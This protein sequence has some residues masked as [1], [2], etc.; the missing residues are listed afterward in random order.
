[1]RKKQLLFGF[2]GWMLFAAGVQAKRPAFAPAPYWRPVNTVTVDG[3]EIVYAESGHGPA[4]LLVHGWAG[5]LYNW[6]EVMEPLSRSFR[7]VA[8]DLPG[9]GQSGCDSQARY[10]TTAYAD[11]LARFLDTLGIEQTS[12]LG[13]S[14]GGQIAA[15][16]ALRH[17]ERVQKLILCDA[18]GAGGFPAVMK[19]AAVVLRPRSMIPLLH[20]AFPV[21]AD[22]LAAMPES[23]RMRVALAEERYRSEVRACTGRALSDALKSMIRHGLTDELGRIQAP[24]LVLWGS[25]DDLLPVTFAEAFAARIPGA[26]LAVIEGGRHTPMQWRPEQFVSIV[27]E[28]LSPD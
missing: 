20:L 8:L 3:V 13:N 15:E 10:T 18:A 22:K 12:V 26:E 11:F 24:T 6:K 25:D 4:L 28:F 2:L 27:T 21:R 5:N 9:S 23:E 19:P 7:V 14:M 17:P 16:F 1:M